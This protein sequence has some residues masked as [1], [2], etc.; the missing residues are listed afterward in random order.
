MSVLSQSQDRSSGLSDHVHWQLSSLSDE[1][2]HNKHVLRIVF[3]QK[4][5]ALSPI[6]AC[7]GFPLA[8]G[9]CEAC[10]TMMFLVGVKTSGVST[11]RGNIFLWFNI[12]PSICEI[13][14]YNERWSSW[15]IISN[16]VSLHAGYRS[17]HHILAVIEHT[18]QISI[19]RH[20]QLGILCTYYCYLGTSY[21]TLVP[22][23]GSKSTLFSQC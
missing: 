4:S 8:L 1:A 7:L 22:P 10:H 14:G 21:V 17:G 5:L 20:T 13:K 3:T 18:V 15:E 2:H 11:P 16:T 6:F 12:S 9:V 23:K 19:Q